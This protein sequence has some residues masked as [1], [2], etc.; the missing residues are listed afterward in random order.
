[1]VK[2]FT[3][4][5]TIRKGCLLS[6]LLFNIVLEVLARVIRQGKEIKLCIHI[7]KEKVN[8]SVCRCYDQICTKS[9]TLHTHRQNC[10]KQIQESGRIQNQAQRWC[11]SVASLYT[12]NKQSE[13]WVKKTVPCKIAW[14]RIKYIEINQEGDKTSAIKI[15]EHAEWN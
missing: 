6:L 7:R 1:M 3:I 9:W 4:L 11:I 5:T 13:T 15:I 12:D 14:W 2:H 10:Y 8:L